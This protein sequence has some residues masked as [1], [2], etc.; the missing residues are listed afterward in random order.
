MTIVISPAFLFDVA[1]GEAAEAELWNGIAEQQLTDWEGEWIPELF[2][3]MQ[4][5]KRAGVERQHW[6]QS[7]HWDW[8][9]KTQALQGF[10][11]APGFSVMCGGITQ[12]MMIVDSAM[13]RCRIAEQLGQHVVY[14]DY[15]ETAPWNRK[16]LLFDPPRYKGVGSIL[17]RAAIELSLEEGFKGRIGLHSLSHA[18]DWYA[19]KC[20]MADLGV[21]Q[22]KENLHYFEMTSAQADAFIGKGNLP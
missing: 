9:K 12:G 17:I 1:R 7:L 3:A 6:P 11:T 4:R 20:G 22:N 2:S 16:E 14:V 21:D 10:L 8:R 19:N 18:Y 15:L 13:H 5:L